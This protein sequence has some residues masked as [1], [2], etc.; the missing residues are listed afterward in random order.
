MVDRHVDSPC[1][2]PYGNSTAHFQFFEYICVPFIPGSSDITNVLSRTHI[3][4]DMAVI[5]II[6][7]IAKSI[8]FMFCPLGLLCKNH[9]KIQVVRRFRTIR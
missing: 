2:C 6:E 1:I 7:I 3:V 8:F 5:G 4:S 9:Q